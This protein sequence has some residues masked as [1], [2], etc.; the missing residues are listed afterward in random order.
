[1]LIKAG[2]RHIKC[3]LCLIQYTVTV[4]TCQIFWDKN[5]TTAPN[6]SGSIFWTFLRISDV[7]YNQTLLTAAGWEKNTPKYVH[8]GRW[9][10]YTVYYNLPGEVKF[11]TIQYI[12]FS[13]HHRNMLSH[14]ENQKCWSHLFATQLSLRSTFKFW[15]LFVTWIRDWKVTAPGFNQPLNHQAPSEGASW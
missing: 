2:L 11:G 9:R 12:C 10:A 3:F 14:C 4:Y 1:M 13:T 7:K 6:K 8:Q 5:L 15:W